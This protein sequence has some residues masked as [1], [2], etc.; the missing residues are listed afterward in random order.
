[1]YGCPGCGSM[2]TFDIPEQQ[3]KCGRCGR[4]ESIEEADRREARRAGSSF[5]VDVLTCP[6]CGAE[7]RTMNTAAAGFCSYCGSSVLLD[8]KAADMEAPETIAP[9]RVTREECFAKYQEM[10]RKSLCADHRLKKN[11]TAESFRGIY[12]PQYI[13]SAAVRGETVLEG[14]QTKGNDTYYYNTSVTLNHQFDHILH[15]ASKEMPDAMSEKIARVEPED[16]KP[17]SP[18]YISGYYADVPDTEESAYEPYARA[19]AV[20]LGLKDVLE[21]LDDG[22]TYPTAE[23]EKK[24]VG[25]ATAKCTGRTLMPVWF[26]SIRSG[27]RLLYAIQN[28]VTGEM[29]ADLPMD[30]PRFGLIALA[31]AV[32]L[33][34][35][36]NAFLTLRPEMVLVTAMLLAIFAQLIVN[37]HRKSIQDK[38]EAEKAK[39]G[40]DDLARRLKQQKR[41]ASHAKGGSAAALEG[42]GGMFGVIVL[43]GGIYGMSQLNNANAFRIAALVLTLGMGALVVLG[44]GKGT[45]TPAGSIA[46][47]A[48]MIA[49]TLNMIL[50]PFHSDDLPVYVI[51]LLCMAA[52]IWVSVDLLMLHNKECSNPM[53]QF[54][55][56]QGGEEHA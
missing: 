53:P 12:V 27:K 39:D 54:E 46:A 40:G 33:F 2:M 3:L 19:E 1:M 29:A 32:P 20:R 30:I 17:F 24:L 7:I 44:R 16:F 36:F 41:M 52:V 10:V 38:A 51:A 18:A 31:L 21:D 49:G 48:A 4:T 5:S 14:H 26:M 13:Y 11:V 34:F 47:L 43:I 8:R 45:K 56:H 37:R 9:F 15:D 55:T 25:L 23:A 50:D 22:Y 35:L 28:G 6:T 42:F